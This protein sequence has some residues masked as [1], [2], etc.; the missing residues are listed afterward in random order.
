V[1]PHAWMALQLTQRGAVV[2]IDSVVA[3]PRS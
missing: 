1:L 3:A 2:V